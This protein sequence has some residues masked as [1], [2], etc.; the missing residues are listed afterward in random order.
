[1]LACADCADCHSKIV[2]NYKRTGMG[3]SFSRPA[4][5][6]AGTFY[7]AASDTHFSVFARGGKFIERRWQVGF[8]GAETN[9]DEKEI[10][11]VMGSGAQARTFLHRTASGA[12][13]QLP[14]GWYSE[15]G[16]FYAMSPGYDTPDQPNS[17]RKIPYECMFCHNAYPQIPAENAQFRAEPVFTKIPEGIDCARCHGPGDR[18]EALA[19]SGAG[20]SAIRNAI[21]NPA[22]LDRDRQMEVCMQ[23]HLE[24]T[25]FPFPHSILKFDRHPFSFQP[26][27]RLGDF[28]LYFDHPEPDRFQIVSSAYRLRMSKCFLKSGSLECTTCHDQHAAASAEQACLKCHVDLKAE[29]RARSSCASCHMQKRR[30]IDVVHAVMTDH[31]IQRKPPAIDPSAEI[32]EP[33]GPETMYRGEVLPYYTS[34]DEKYLALA[35]IRE[36]NN[37]EGGIPRLRAALEKDKNAAAE[38]FIELGDASGDPAAYKEALRRHPNFLPALIGLGDYE[39]AVR[40]APDDSN[41]WFRLGDEYTKQR[42]T[43]EAIEALEKSIRID[44]EM[45]EAHFAL[46]MT[47]AQ[48]AKDPARAEVE[49]RETIRLR[50][51]DAASHMNLAI[52]LFGSKRAEE[53]AFHF[54]RALRYRPDYALGHLNYG[55]MLQAIG[56]REVAIEHLNRA[57]RSEDPVVRRSAL[58]ALAR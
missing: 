57:A 10:D 13:Q 23:C 31:F 3:R 46:A 37:I 43:R 11:F 8:G 38:F 42:R 34:A 1:M 36:G 24:T 40:V 54:E 45:A 53:S 35:Q 32:A 18:H 30:T 19:K 20:L 29:H 22:R 7:H 21:V 33:H 25:S 56:K 58:D 26:G 44:P 41:A 27:E 47:L 52:L 28:Q 48:Q 4:N 9:V 14:L 50:P 6:P 12:L 49:F 17:R 15:K 39:K 5:I 2:E 51:N 55:L 16:G